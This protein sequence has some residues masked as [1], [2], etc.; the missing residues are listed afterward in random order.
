MIEHE[1]V[2][3]QFAKNSWKDPAVILMEVSRLKS[4]Y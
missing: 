4:Y 3:E 1:A 2:V